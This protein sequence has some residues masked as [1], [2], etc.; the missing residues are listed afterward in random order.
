MS[1]LKAVRIV[2]HQLDCLL[3]HGFWQA[4]DRGQTQEP[5]S[6][7][8]E[9][10]P[11]LVRGA[12][13]DVRVALM[14]LSALLTTTRTVRH[15]DSPSTNLLDSCMGHAAQ[16]SLTNVSCGN[17]HTFQTLY[18]QSKLFAGIPSGVRTNHRYNAQPSRGS[19][20]VRAA[21]RPQMHGS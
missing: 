12:H 4:L 10:L 17:L 3:P 14:P 15:S 5:N 19:E 6:D 7:G 13:G 16:C 1:N 9:G 2:A 21:A 20:G 8:D 11:L 18:G